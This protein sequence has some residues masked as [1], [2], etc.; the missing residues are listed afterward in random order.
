MNGRIQILQIEKSS[1][2]LVKLFFITLK[3]LMQ[4]F[5]VKSEYR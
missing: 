5:S 2:Y 3:N 4:S 1:K